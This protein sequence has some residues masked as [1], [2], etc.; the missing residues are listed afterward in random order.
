MQL[1]LLVLA[2]PI[3]LLALALALPP[4][5]PTTLQV[6]FLRLYSL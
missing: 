2:A 3:V 5:V 1:V 6:R 4:V